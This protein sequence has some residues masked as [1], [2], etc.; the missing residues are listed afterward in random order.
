MDAEQSIEFVQP[1]DLPSANTPSPKPAETT[2]SSSYN[3]ITPAPVIKSRKRTSTSTDNTTSLWDASG[4][5]WSIAMQ[6]VFQYLS[7]VDIL[8]CSTVCKA[9]QQAKNSDRYV[10]G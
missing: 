7:T 5:K 8:R 9:W 6:N 1:I 10:F 4:E 2:K 3:F